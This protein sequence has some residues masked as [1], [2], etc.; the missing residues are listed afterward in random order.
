[1]E[2]K[3]EIPSICTYRGLK[4]EVFKRAHKKAKEAETSGKVLMTDD[5]KNIVH[6]SW[7]EVK[8]EIKEICSSI[9][10]IDEIS[11]D[12]FVS[13]EKP[14]DIPEEKLEPEEEPIEDEQ[15]IEQ[16]EQDEEEIDTVP[17]SAST[18]EKPEKQGLGERQDIA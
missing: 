16:I 17:E 1:M 14:E 4:P 13:N 5:W 18:G 7:K 3:E 2:P 15:I 8:E 11:K 9:P 12:E 10:P 6:Q